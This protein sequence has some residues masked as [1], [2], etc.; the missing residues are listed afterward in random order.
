MMT[1]PIVGESG[2]YVVRIDNVTAAPKT[3]T[4]ETEQKQLTGQVKGNTQSGINNA[5]TKLNDVKDTRKIR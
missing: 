4:Y 1:S 2:V 5:L 3:A